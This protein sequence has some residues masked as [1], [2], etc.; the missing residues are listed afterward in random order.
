MQQRS[1]ISLS[2]LNYHRCPLSWSQRY[3][4]VSMANK[5]KKNEVEKRSN[6]CTNGEGREVSSALLFCHFAVVLPSKKLPLPLF[7]LFK[8]KVH[9]PRS[10]GS[11]KVP[12][13]LAMRK[14]DRYMTTCNL[15]A[16]TQHINPFPTYQWMMRVP[17]PP[18]H[19]GTNL[20]PRSSL[21]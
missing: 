7:T 1:F 10:S 15:I 9:S 4:L 20:L 6:E 21:S 17:P 3:F 11:R 8:A 2:V 16:T 13:E 19:H 14:R 12:W 18:L 5:L